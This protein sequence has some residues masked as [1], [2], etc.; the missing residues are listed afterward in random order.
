MLTIPE[1]VQERVRHLLTNQPIDAPYAFERVRQEFFQVA[2]TAPYEA[3]VLCWYCLQS[4]QTQV[5]VLRRRVEE[6]ER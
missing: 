2:E 6:L 5:N 3:F 4:L 1:A